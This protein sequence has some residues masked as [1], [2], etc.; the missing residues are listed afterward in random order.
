M[1]TRTREIDVSKFSKIPFSEKGRN[2]SGCNC[3]GLVQVIYS[4]NLNVQLP[5]YHDE[6]D[7][8]E[9]R[10]ELSRLVEQGK[11]DWRE[12]ESPEPYD[13]ILFRLR[14]MPTHLGVYIGKGK[15][16]HCMRDSGTSVEKLNSIVWKER[17]VG[18]Y[19]H[20]TR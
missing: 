17:V 18:Y 13:L 10:E 1:L 11:V 14:S 9:D 3:H 7:T 12:V 19:R 15:F 8:L 5:A 4:V 16:I 2:F 20:F 6:Y